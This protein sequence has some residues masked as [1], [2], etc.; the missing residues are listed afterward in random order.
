[1]KIAFILLRSSIGTKMFGDHRSSP[2]GPAGEDIHIYE[3][4]EFYQE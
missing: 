2:A 4:I 1:M 3:S